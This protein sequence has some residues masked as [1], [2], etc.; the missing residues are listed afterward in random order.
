MAKAYA[1]GDK[2]Q[3]GHFCDATVDAIIEKS[4]ATNYFPGSDVIQY[5][6]NN[7]LPSTNARRV[8]VAFYVFRGSMK[9]L[10]HW[11]CRQNV[12]R[13]FLFDLAE[14]FYIK[15]SSTDPTDRAKTSSSCV[16]HRHGSGICYTSR[17]HR[18]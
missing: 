9:W 3:A 13:E 10:D 12:P 14:L 11:T 5:F 7:T 8:F 17:G 16:Y 6:Y 15:D 4:R 18:K 1:L 2:I